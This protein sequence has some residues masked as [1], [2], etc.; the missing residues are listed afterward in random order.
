MKKI[1]GLLAVALLVSCAEL[2]HIAKNVD[3]NKVLEATTGT[4]QPLDIAG[5]LKQALN[6]GVS[7]QVTKLTS[8]NGFYNNQLVRIAL[9]QEL[10]QVDKTLRK[11]GLGSLADKGLMALNATAEDA[12]KTATP[13]FVSAIK[14]MT[15]TDA[16]NIL[17]GTDNA[18]TSYLQKTTNTK[19]YNSFNPVIKQSFDKVGAADIWKEVITKYNSVPFI[20]KV[21][22]DLTDY[23]TNQALAGVFKMIAV[24]EKEIRTDLSERTSTLLQKVFALQD[25]K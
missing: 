22:P 15:F 10:Q 12:V 20:T 1:V 3:I 2:H 18:A 8:K 24:E 16:K 5:G 21:N 7:D 17:M 14:E 13:I 11:I 4:S 6:K 23:V 9:P 25:K 19:L